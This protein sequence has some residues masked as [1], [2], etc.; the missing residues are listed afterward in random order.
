MDLEVFDFHGIQDILPLEI[1]LRFDKKIE[2][3][4]HPDHRGP[5]RAEWAEFAQAEADWGARLCSAWTACGAT[6][7]HK[8]KQLYKYKK[9][10]KKSQQKNVADYTSN[11]REE[12]GLLNAAVDVSKDALDAHLEICEQNIPNLDIS[13]LFELARTSVGGVGAGGEGVGTPAKGAGMHSDEAIAELATRMQEE[14]GLASSDEDDDSRVVNNARHKELESKKGALRRAKGKGDKD[15]KAAHEAASNA[16]DFTLADL[17]IGKLYAIAE[18]VEPEGASSDA[19]N[20]G[21]LVAGAHIVQWVVR[22]VT[23]KERSGLARTRV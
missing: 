20:D 12:Y 19:T 4:I 8:E 16:R 23:R 22:E 14:F 5:I 21:Q 13:R 9:E 7:R 10:L 6:L 17:K 18:V 11:E 3:H 15:A 1:M 2:Q